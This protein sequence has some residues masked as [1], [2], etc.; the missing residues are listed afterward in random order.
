M[1]IGRA[2]FNDNG[3]KGDLLK[4]YLIVREVHDPWNHST[5]SKLRVPGGCG[6]HLVFALLVPFKMV[7][8]EYV[9]MIQCKSEGRPRKCLTVKCVGG[10]CSMMTKQVFKLLMASG[11]KSRKLEPCFRLSPAPHVQPP[12]PP[13][14][15]YIGVVGAPVSETLTTAGVLSTTPVPSTSP[16]PASSQPQASTSP[17]TQCST[18]PQLQTPPV[19][20]DASN[21]PNGGNMSFLANSLEQ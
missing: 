11:S 16:Q 19:T 7:L 14:G 10:S 21:V 18:P 13:S 9:P 2:S 8:E 15:S 3:E 6:V 4:V 1:V 5:K 17:Q 12:A 20:S